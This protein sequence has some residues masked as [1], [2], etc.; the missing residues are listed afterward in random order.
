MQPIRLQDKLQKIF[1]PHAKKKRSNMFAVFGRETN[2][3][4]DHAGETSDG[5]PISAA[6]VEEA[7]EYLKK[8][9]GNVLISTGSKELH[10][11]TR[12]KDYK[13]R[14]FARVLSTQEAVAEAVRLGFE[15]KHLIAM[16]GPYSEELNLAM[17]K[18]INAAYFVTK[19][20][21]GAGGFEEKKKA[22]QKAGAELIV[23]AR[24]K[25]EGK[26]LQEVKKLME[27]FLAKENLL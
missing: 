15:G 2:D 17:L 14:C 4:A 5:R 11:Y 21:G 20:S 12:I 22:A 9:G 3:P 13:E 25:E 16:Q 7:V 27:E 24:P 1:A 18:H 10:L 8:T 19:E 6:S 23:I 26:S